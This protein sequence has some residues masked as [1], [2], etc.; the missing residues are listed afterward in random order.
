M[1]YCGSVYIKINVWR[2]WSRQVVWTTYLIITNMKFCDLYS[3][4]NQLKITTIIRQ[5]IDLKIPIEFRETVKISNYE[6]F[7]IFFQPCILTINIEEPTFM[8]PLF[9][10]NNTSL[11]LFIDK[12]HNG[13]GVSRYTYALH[14]ILWNVCCSREF[15]F[16]L[17]HILSSL[18]ELVYRSRLLIDFQC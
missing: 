14:F 9:Q 1:T 4:S 2:L 16:L 15:V 6:R 3:H 12:H 18:S 10:M 5:P 17:C 13:N 8:A 7:E 11:H